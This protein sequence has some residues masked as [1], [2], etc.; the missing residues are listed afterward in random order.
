MA[1]QQRKL[2]GL[3]PAAAKWVWPGGWGWGGPRGGVASGPGVVSAPGVMGRLWKRAPTLPLPPHYHPSPP[4]LRG[5]AADPMQRP[6][7][8]A[9]PFPST[10]GAPASAPLAPPNRATT[11]LGGLGSPIGGGGGTAYGGAY[12][13]GAGQLP[14]S[15][16]PGLATPGGAGYDYQGGGGWAGTPMST[17]TG[18]SRCAHV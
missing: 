9:V 16:T 5:A 11:R 12:G 3:P 14:G 2:F 6:R 10:P 13:G 7:P 17:S 8:P 1:P 18:F 4:L 15:S